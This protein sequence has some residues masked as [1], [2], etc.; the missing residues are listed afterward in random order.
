MYSVKKKQP[1]DRITQ[2]AC[3]AIEDYLRESDQKDNYKKQDII[4]LPIYIPFKNKSTKY[5]ITSLKNISIIPKLEEN[6][7][8]DIIK[9]YI[10]SENAYINTGNIFDDTGIGQNE[11]KT[12]IVKSQIK[13]NNKEKEE[14]SGNT[15]KLEILED[16]SICIKNTTG[17]I[18][19]SLGEKYI[20]LKNSN[21]EDNN[22][23]K[24]ID[25]D[26]LVNS[27]LLIS[28]NIKY[29]EDDENE[30]ENENDNN[31]K[32]YMTVNN[33]SNNNLIRNKDNLFELKDEN[34]IF[35]SNL[36]NSKSLQNIFLGNNN[37]NN[38]VYFSASKKN[39]LK[40][41]NDII[42]SDKNINNFRINK[43]ISTTI[44]KK[45]L[46]MENKNQKK[47][48]NNNIFDIETSKENKEKKNNY[49]IKEIQINNNNNNYN[50]LNYKRM[51]FGDNF[52][53]DDDIINLWKYLCNKCIKNYNKKLLSTN[54]QII[55][56]NLKIEKILESKN[57][58]KKIIQNNNNIIHNNNIK[59]EDNYFDLIKEEYNNIVQDNIAQTINIIEYNNSNN[60]KNR[61]ETDSEIIYKPTNISNIIN[62]PIINY[63]YSYEKIFE[64]LD[65]ISEESIKNLKNESYNKI[66]KYQGSIE[67]I[68]EEI[69]ESYEEQEINDDKKQNKIISNI[70]IN[71]PLIDQCK[72]N[73]DISNLILNFN[74]IDIINEKNKQK[75]ENKI[76]EID[77][78][79]YSPLSAISRNIRFPNSNNRN[80]SNPLDSEDI[81][82]SKETET[83]MSDEEIITD[84]NGKIIN[85]KSLINN[86]LIYNIDINNKDNNKIKLIFCENNLNNNKNKNNNIN[87][88]YCIPIKSYKKILKMIFYKKRKPINKNSYESLLSI[89]INNFYI[90]KREYSLKKN[91]KNYNIQEKEKLNNNCIKMNN[92]I[93]ELEEK[94]KEMKSYYIFGLIK[95]QII[96][97]KLEK[98]KFIKNLKIG[99]KRNKIKRLYK[100]IIDILNNQINDKEINVNYYQKMIDVI[101][102][103][104]K[105]TDEDIIEGKLKYNNINNI[106]EMN[107]INE[108]QNNNN[109]DNK[110]KNNKQKIFVLL[111]PMVFIINYFANNFKIYEFNDLR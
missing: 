2:D 111:L 87:K 78:L 12:I 94:I 91:K 30:N 24:E 45:K 100:E 82:V 42:N 63:N 105:I 20:E 103:Y 16:G 3:S 95:K 18:S 62:P 36:K 54:I 68:N 70:K 46:I 61:N 86:F 26:I 35:N 53:E 73:L 34:Q 23:N 97:D 93:N 66:K 81:S 65:I 51:L 60:N 52:V 22:I 67:S 110:I 83:E 31:D 55:T 49:F 104:E 27:K 4:S 28:N 71:N 39:K 98:R 99:E 1:K 37:F 8:S 59:S 33:I 90:F 102:K 84:E 92:K 6:N 96:K 56:Q 44:R 58:Q 80:I 29:L 106:N 38:F 101:K 43:K 40:Y 13:E 75:K 5:R 88:R 21:F 9:Q 47:Y 41:N 10:K 14:I 85:N 72:I 76:Q 11:S 50:E 57:K 108:M 48:N 74:K 109:L 64:E 17:M 69:N 32:E 25:Q 7:F 89:I 107:K 79:S 15:E 77:Y 19:S